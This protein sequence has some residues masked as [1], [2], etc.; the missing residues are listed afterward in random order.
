MEFFRWRLVE[1][2]ETPSQGT[3]YRLF[4]GG[5]D[6]VLEACGAR[7]PLPIGAL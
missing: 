4:S 7:R 5:W 1:A 2:P 3:V 6:A